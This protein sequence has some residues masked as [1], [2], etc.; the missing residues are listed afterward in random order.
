MDTTCGRSSRKQSATPSLPAP[1][2]ALPPQIQ[3]RVYGNSLGKGYHR[4]P[5]RSRT[6]FQIV[7]LALPRIAMLSIAFR[8]SCFGLLSTLGT[9]SFVINRTRRHRHE[10]R[11]APPYSPRNCRA[12][13]SG[14]TVKTRPGKTSPGR[15][16]NSLIF[17]Y[18]RYCIW[19]AAPYYAS[20]DP[21]GR[22][23]WR[24]TDVEHN[25]SNRR[26]NDRWRSP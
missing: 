10:A 26:R 3:A 8:H 4:F 24:S 14:R 17:L 5:Q 1:N 20:P 13:P 2:P 6:L 7:R 16:Q 18:R 21:R 23:V 25:P 9:S 12:P 19:G 22:R 15:P 11:L